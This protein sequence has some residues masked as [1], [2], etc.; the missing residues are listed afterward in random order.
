MAEAPFNVDRALGVLLIAILLNAFL[1]GVVTQ[2]LYSYWMSRFEDTIYVKLF[3]VAQFALVV[4]QSSMYWQLAWS[5]YVTGLSQVVNVK[6]VTWQGLAG[7]VCRV[8]LI[9]MAN[10]F[11]AS[12]IYS[13]TRS[14]LQSGLV[15]AFSTAAFITGIVTIWTTWTSKPI[16]SPTSASERAATAVWNVLQVITECLIMLFFSRALV[17]SRSG[18]ETSNSVVNHLIRNVIQ[19]GL[20]AT[21]WSLATLGTSFLLPQNTVYT[22]F[23]ATCGSIYVHMIYDGLLSRPRLRSRLADRSQLEMRLPTQFSP[24]VSRASP[25]HTSEGKRS[26]GAARTHATTVSFVIPMDLGTATQ[27]T[28][29][30][31]EVDKDRNLEFGSEPPVKSEEGYGLSV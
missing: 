9:M 27:N 12:R 24:S 31:S 3:V 8:V 1:F 10:V 16:L 5:L 4:V 20:I 18:L 11:L 14:R 13:L 7:A 28:S 29:E 22:L 26:S 6:S 25:L 2:Q 19:I 21:I 17:A 30:P 15:L 23:D